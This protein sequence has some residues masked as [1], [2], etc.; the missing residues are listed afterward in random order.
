[1][2]ISNDVKEYIF[3]ITM[4]VITV[5]LTI[6]SLSF[7]TY[8]SFTFIFYLIIMPLCFYFSR[9]NLLFISTLANLFMVIFFSEYI[10]IYTLI[11]LLAIPVLFIT[12]SIK[13]PSILT[14]K[15]YIFIISFIFIS[16]I[17]SN[18]KLLLGPISINNTHENMIFYSPSNQKSINYI[19]CLA[20]YSALDIEESPMFIPVA[21]NINDFYRIIHVE[22]NHKNN[23]SL[24]NILIKNNKHTS[25]NAFDILKNIFIY[26]W[27][28]QFYIRSGG[29]GNLPLF[30][31][32]PQR[33]SFDPKFEF[34]TNYKCSFPYIN[35]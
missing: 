27:N 1:M 35:K 3:T 6:N 2:N 10:N 25:I 11:P 13:Q 12:K 24:Y 8:A 9:R 32:I 23:I 30:V 26:I 19:Q 17:F 20:L 21:T 16:I 4:S 7:Y 33:P 15:K 31:G 14:T 29:N 28:N 22:N 5:I 34:N 18:Y